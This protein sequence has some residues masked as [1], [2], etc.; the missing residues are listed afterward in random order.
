MLVDLHVVVESVGRKDEAGDSLSYLGGC[1]F[2]VLLCPVC[3]CLVLVSSNKLPCHWI[4]AIYI[5]A[6][7]LKAHGYLRTEPFVAY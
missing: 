2:D 1:F 4:A 6:L 3:L 7:V 5:T